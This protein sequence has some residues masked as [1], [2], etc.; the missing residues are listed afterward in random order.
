MYI[1][2]YIYILLIIYI[3]IY[4]YVCVCIKMYQRFTRK[5]VSPAPSLLMQSEVFATGTKASETLAV[6]RPLCCCRGW[7][8]STKYR[9]ICSWASSNA[10]PCG[11]CMVQ[12]LFLIGTRWSSLMADFPAFSFVKSFLS[13][14]WRIPAGSGSLQNPCPLSRAWLRQKVLQEAQAELATMSVDGSSTKEK[15][16]I[17]GEDLRVGVWKRIVYTQK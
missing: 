9:R 4:I 12:Q 2:A 15:L 7:R 14:M 10:T 17:Q 1:V 8:V 11:L 5:L 6:T 16:V 3:Y 13:D